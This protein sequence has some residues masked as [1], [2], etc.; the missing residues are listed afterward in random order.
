MVGMK[1]LVTGSTSGIG[2]E[3]AKGLARSGACVMLSGL[4]D[5]DTAIK[6]VQNAARTTNKDVKVDYHGADMR[7]AEEIEELIAAAERR[8]FGTLDIVVNNAG[9][10]HLAKVEEFPV[11]KWNEIIDINLNSAFH[12]TRLTL[13]GMKE[14]NWGRIINVASIHGLVACGEKRIRYIKAWIVRAH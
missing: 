6:E 14:K 13:P 9:I 10:Q 8:L 5:Y 7:K 4:G 3:I 2:R 12:T 11:Q 1:A